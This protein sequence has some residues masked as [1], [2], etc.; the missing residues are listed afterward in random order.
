MKLYQTGELAQKARIS[1]RTLR[2]YDKTGLLSP[3][4][5]SEAG[6]RLYT[7]S[8]LQRLQY[9]LA[10]KYLGFSLDEIKACLQAS[11]RHLSERLAQQKAMLLDKRAE[12]DLILRAVDASLHLLRKNPDDPEALSS[13]LHVYQAEH[14]Q[15][16]VR[17]HLTPSQRSHMR[18]L[19]ET[20]YS[21]EARRKLES[22]EWTD[23]SRREHYRQYDEFRSTLQRLTAENADPTSPQAQHMAHL[24]TQINARVSQNDP[25][26]LEGMKTAWNR[27]NELPEDKRPPAYHFTDAERDFLK[28]AMTHFHSRRPATP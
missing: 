10:L 6:Y 12:L 5:H 21:E 24:L 25:A 16:R 23:E 13:I 19:Y 15:E 1:I 7:E 22:R 4:Q 2:Y 27:Y 17:Q 18:E 3:S 8:D 14:N 26:V 20:S 11:P 9:I 28:R